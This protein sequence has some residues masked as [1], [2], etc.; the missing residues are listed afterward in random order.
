MQFLSHLP[1]QNPIP[2]HKK[3]LALIWAS[4]DISKGHWW[5]IQDRA[6]VYD[7]LYLTNVLDTCF[8][9]KA[10]SEHWYIM[11]A[12]KK[13]GYITGFQVLSYWGQYYS[14]L[15]DLNKNQCSG[16][17]IHFLVILANYRYKTN[18]KDSD[19]FPDNFAFLNIL[20]TCFLFLLPYIPTFSL[21]SVSD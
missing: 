4:C 7:I 3:Q 14:I 9:V 16:L 6:H 2:N 17:F 18:S 12:C 21:S 11:L 20:K 5:H 13:T 10:L 1:S 19:T 15:S 8:K